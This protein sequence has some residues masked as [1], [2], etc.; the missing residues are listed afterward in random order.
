MDLLSST[1]TLVKFNK[2][3]LMISVKITKVADCQ[4]ACSALLPN[5]KKILDKQE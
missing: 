5:Y 2:L 1:G 3:I 4:V